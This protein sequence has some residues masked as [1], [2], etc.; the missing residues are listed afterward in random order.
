MATVVL[1][2]AFARRYTAGVTRLE[3]TALTYQ[4]LVDELDERYPG[5]AD[6]VNI[7]IAIAIDGE[8]HN[9]PLLQTIE[10]S[11]E[12]FFLPPLEGG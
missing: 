8:I 3:V 7:P 10:P 12:V 11:S 6:A 2:P 9:E 1:Q 5:F 4:A